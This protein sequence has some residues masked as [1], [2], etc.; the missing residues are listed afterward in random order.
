MIDSPGQD[1]TSPLDH[2]TIQHQS[3]WSDSSSDVCVKL[4]GRE[5]MDLEGSE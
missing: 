1:Q 3:A 2:L 5:A 4:E